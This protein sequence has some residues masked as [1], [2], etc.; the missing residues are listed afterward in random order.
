MKTMLVLDLETVVD[1]AI[2]KGH[3]RAEK[4][5]EWE[6]VQP[7]GSALFGQMPPLP[8]P[9]E[10]FLVRDTSQDF[11]VLSRWRI[12]SFGAFSFQSGFRILGFGYDLPGQFSETLALHQFA[13]LVGEHTL[14]TWNGRRF[15]LPLIGVRALAQGVPIP[16]W[17]RQRSARYRYSDAAHLDLHDYL[18]D[19]GAAHVGHLDQIVRLIGFPGK[20]AG[21]GVGALTLHEEGRF[22]E[23]HRYCLT[24]VAQTAALA[25]RVDYL[26]GELPAREALA[27]AECLLDH[28][29]KSEELSELLAAVD[30]DKF[31]GS[32]R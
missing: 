10:R 31:L 5:I 22:E 25:I 6:N 4:F 1:P 13:E 27:D 2:P 19:F 32:F 17:Y 3:D 15:D 29:A 8:M 14:V 23:L 24:D 30:K 11:A 20:I 26:R 16:G 9:T 21:D 18:S 7:P 28:M 12:T